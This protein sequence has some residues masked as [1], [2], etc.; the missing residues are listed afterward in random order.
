M[1]LAHEVSINRMCGKCAR[2]VR[3]RQFDESHFVHTDTL[4]LHELTND[5]VLVAVFT[6]YCE[7]LPTQVAQTCSGKIF[8]NDHRGAVAMPEIDDLYRD[9]LFTQLHREW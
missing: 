2:H 9:A 3:W 5:Q 6:W 8:S 1:W 4:I 7:R